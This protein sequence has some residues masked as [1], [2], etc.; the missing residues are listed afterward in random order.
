MKPGNARAGHGRQARPLL[1]RL[2]MNNRRFLA[3]LVTALGAAVLV[4]GC[5]TDDS[6]DLNV[7][8]QSD[9][10]IVEL[11]VT[12]VDNSDWGPNLLGGDTLDPGSTISINVSCDTY[13][14]LLVDES[15][16]DC[17]LHSVDLCFSD[18][19]WV[20]RNNTCT[21]FAAA[22]AQREAEAAA[23]AAAAK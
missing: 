8:N 13:D 3:S 4:A 6:S 16:V 5:T 1:D 15:G 23:K 14:A 12:Q 7:T 17:E 20:I 11:H 19:D 2:H 18:A 22:K 10:S 21:V 9:F